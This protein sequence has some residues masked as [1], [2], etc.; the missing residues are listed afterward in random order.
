MK[1]LLLIVAFLLFT[2]YAFSCSLLTSPTSGFDMADY[3]FIGEVVEV[4]SVKYKR[5]KGEAEAI[6]L[7]I[8]VSEN[9]YS[10]KLAS[11]YEVI[12]L[13]LYADCSVGSDTKEVH[14]H[15]P[16]GSQVRVVAQ[17]AIVIKNQLADSTVRLETSIYNRG[18]IARNDLNESL[19][20]SAKTFYDYKSFVERQRT[21]AAEEALH[22]SNY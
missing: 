18:S 13:R 10:P 20:T 17:E 15:Y 1:Y 6:G 9:V 7:K 14:E 5:G 4:K 16:V 19:R 22:D 3:I 2:N 8:K 21:T 12:P 11:Y